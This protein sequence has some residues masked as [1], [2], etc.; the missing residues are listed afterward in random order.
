[1]RGGGWQLIPRP[2]LPGDLITLGATV[3]LPSGNGGGRP[4]AG[5]LK[6]TSEGKGIFSHVSRGDFL[7]GRRPAFQSCGSLLRPLPADWRP[8]VPEAGPLPEGYVCPLLSP[9]NLDS[10]RETVPQVLTS[11][12][13]LPVR[14][15][16][17]AL[18][19]M[20]VRWGP[21]HRPPDC[22]IPLLSSLD[23]RGVIPSSREGPPPGLCAQRVGISSFAAQPG[24]CPLVALAKHPLSARHAGS[25][26][27]NLCPSRWPVF[28]GTEGAGWG[29]CP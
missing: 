17:K 13:G 3:S 22:H 12:R 25:S 24:R 7:P 14:N 11:P 20:G 9:P 6:P 18:V 26:P 16:Q 23:A 2:L 4:A 10:V 1:M 5:F 15:G 19:G 27:G 28:G 29:C 21:G 8:S